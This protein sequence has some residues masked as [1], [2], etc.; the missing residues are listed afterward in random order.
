[1]GKLNF[2]LSEAY[3]HVVTS[4]SDMPFTESIKRIDLY[5]SV[6]KKYEI[7]FIN[8]HLIRM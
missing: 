5:V 3:N 4:C 8:L 2:I 7:H 6:S 1:M